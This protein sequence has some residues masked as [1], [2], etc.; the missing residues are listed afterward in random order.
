MKILIAAGSDFLLC[1]EFIDTSKNP[2]RLKT[3]IPVHP[4][5]K[6]EIPVHCLNSSRSRESNSGFP[7]FVTRVLN[8][9]FSYVHW[10]THN[11]GY[12]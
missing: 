2:P 8:G 5:L 12:S 9:R 10:S 7:A 6:T 3:E 4:R 11:A 1:R